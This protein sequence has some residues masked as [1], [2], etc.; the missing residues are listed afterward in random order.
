MN[1]KPRNYPVLL[2]VA[3]AVAIVLWMLSGIGKYPEASAVSAAD[4]GSVDDEVLQV[5]VQ[6]FNARETTREVLISGR[7][8][9]NRIVEVRAET[10]GSVVG[11]GVERGQAVSESAVLLKLDLRDRNAQLNEAAARVSQR[12]LEFKAVQ[13]LR[14]REFTTDVQIADAAAQLESARAEH[15]RIKLEIANTSV[16]AP[17][18]AVLQDRSVEIG[19]LV[20]TGDTVAQL[21]DLDPLIVVG[22]VNEREISELA[23]GS[24]GTAT[25][26]DGTEVS[27]T[28]RYLAAVADPGTRSFTV[29]LAVANPGNGIRAGQTAEIRL[30]ADRIRVHTLSAALLSLADDGTVG[31]KVVDN[32]QRVK[33]YPVELAGSTP[34]GMQVTGLPDAI[35]LITV[36]QGF[37][38]EGQR[39]DAVTVS[40]PEGAAAYERTD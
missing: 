14:A 35:R 17:I 13:E 22:E 29:E 28:V 1:S 32:D 31:V 7:T 12:E 8:E 23:V 15:E 25:L 33:F 2:S 11:I 27:G 36:G 4:T 19:D 39:V 3:I 37:V 38:T 5:R 18:D 21:V 16:L 6:Q 10:E 9:P 40:S 24:E 30:F 34:E 20:R 26:V